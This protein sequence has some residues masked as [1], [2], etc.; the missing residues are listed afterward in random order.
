MTPHQVVL[1]TGLGRFLIPQF[2]IQMTQ[3]YKEWGLGTTEGTEGV[4][5]LSVRYCEWA[6]T[7]V[8]TSDGNVCYI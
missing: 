7:F 5:S 4:I 6:V 1:E 8:F 2:A 3:C